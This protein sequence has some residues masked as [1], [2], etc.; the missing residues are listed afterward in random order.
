VGDRFVVRP[1]ERIAT[2]GVVV[3]GASAV[4]I[5]MVTGS[6][7][8]LDEV[9]NATSCAGAMPLMNRIRDTGVKKPTIEP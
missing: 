3:D 9:L 6:V 4:D 5:S 2:D 7:A 1:G 8:P